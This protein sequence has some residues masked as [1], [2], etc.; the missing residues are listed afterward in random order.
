MNTTQE[1]DMLSGSAPPSD[2]DAS[3]AS[4]SRTVPVRCGILGCMETPD[5][6]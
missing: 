3:C 5:D 6:I 4:I 1:E 2:S